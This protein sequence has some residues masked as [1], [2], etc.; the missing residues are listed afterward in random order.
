M[1]DFRNKK[2]WFQKQMISWGL[3]LLGKAGTRPQKYESP[4]DIML[5]RKSYFIELIEA[6]YT[7]IKK[8]EYHFRVNG[9]LDI[10]PK[11]A[12]WH[13]IAKQKRGSF[14]GKNLATF[15]RKYFG[16]I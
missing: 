8:T 6:G 7:I 1:N 2:T 5:R 10:Y 4:G 14:H 9:R 16:E 11:N 15:V 12:R 3:W 13:D